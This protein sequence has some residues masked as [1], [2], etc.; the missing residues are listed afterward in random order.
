MKNSNI[1][2]SEE[3]EIAQLRKELEAALVQNNEYKSLI[4]HINDLVCEIDEFGVYT[5]VNHQFKETLG[6]E[7]EELLG[8]QA[9]ETIHPDDLLKSKEKYEEVKRTLEKSVD[10]WRFRHKNGN[11]HTLESRSTIYEDARKGKRTV[12]I[13]RDITEQKLAE[14]KL[15]EQEE[16]LFR[17]TE[18]VPALLALVNSDLTYEFVNRGYEHFLI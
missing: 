17:L 12:A 7:P 10:I 8:H 11:Y 13:S 1:K 16:R 3:K 9:T 5:Y 4:D 15:L 6:Y 18:E 14:K 2:S